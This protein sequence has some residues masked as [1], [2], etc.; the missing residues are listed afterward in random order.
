MVFQ[1]KVY[2]EVVYP[3]LISVIMAEQSLGNAMLD[4]LYLEPF[5]KIRAFVAV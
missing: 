3:M 4:H 2:R 1:N 5:E